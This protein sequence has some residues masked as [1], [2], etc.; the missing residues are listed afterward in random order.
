MKDFFKKI[1]DAI[2]GFFASLYKKVVELLLRIP[3]PKYVWFIVG[4]LACAFLAIVF[5]DAIEWPA[6]PLIMLAAIVC[7]IK[8]MLGKNPK[9][10]NALA[11]S[12]G[13]L[14]IQI[15]AWI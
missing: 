9:W 12:L 11:F 6:F 1:W 10:W 2:K 8:T 5:P 4:L 15:F 13:A 14:V 7:F 3:V